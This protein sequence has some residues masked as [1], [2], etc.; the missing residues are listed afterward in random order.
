MKRD[1]VII[2]IARGGI[3]DEQALYEALRDKT[4][5]GAVIDA[6]YRY[7]SGDDLVARPSELPFHEL[8]NLLMTPHSA[9]WTRGM[10]E[11]RWRSIADNIDALA[12]GDTGALQNVI[13]RPPARDR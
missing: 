7:P 12:R 8:P 1:A 11:R 5:G 9:V 2:N 6:W 4:I 10:I 13:R 3:V